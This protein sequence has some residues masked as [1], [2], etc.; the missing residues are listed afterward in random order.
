[1]QE[2]LLN[3]CAEQLGCTQ[4]AI[5]ISPLSGDAGFRRYYRLHANQHAYI[6]TDAPVEHVDNYAFVDIAER[7]AKAGVLVP[8]IIAVD[9]TQGFLLQSDLGDE[10][11]LS[12]LNDTTVNEYYAQGLAMVVQMQTAK[13]DGLP[14]YDAAMLQREMALFS[15]WF[16]PQLLGVTLG[17]DESQMIAAVYQCLEKCATAQ[18]QA[19]VH[20]DFHSRNILCVGDELATID[21]QDAV[22]GPVTYDAVSLLKDCYIRWPA[23]QVGQW[24]EDFHAAMIE[25]GTYTADRDI[26]DTQRDFH[27]MG[28]Q[29]H[30]KVLGIFAR[31]SLRDGKHGY[32]LDLPM[33]IDYTLEAARLLASDYPILGTFEQWFKQR[34]SPEIAKHAWSHGR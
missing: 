19:F 10:L 34:L 14:H 30:I 6:A 25:Q 4:A 16:I 2:A 21:F 32:L 13:S 26:A 18:P 24:L 5:D 33:V 17:D 23:A 27:A 15:D 28:L 31:L 12:Q 1:M 29:R 9:Y 3:W 7:L 8:K 22:R 11:L 20:R